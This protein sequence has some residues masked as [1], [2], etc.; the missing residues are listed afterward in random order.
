MGSRR[1]PEVSSWRVLVLFVLAVLALYIALDLWDRFRPD[2][3]YAR[4]SPF[5]SS[6]EADFSRLYQADAKR[7]HFRDEAFRALQ[8]ECAEQR[9]PARD[10]LDYIARLRE[11]IDPRAK[12]A[13]ECRRLEF[14]QCV[15]LLREGRAWQEREALSRIWHLGNPDGIEPDY[16]FAWIHLQSERREEAANVAAEAVAAREK[17]DIPD[18]VPHLALYAWLLENAGRF[19]DAKVVEERLSRLAVDPAPPREPEREEQAANDA[20][21]R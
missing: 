16:E 6:L 14:G 9:K 19:D 10:L 13:I 20:R 1:R 7:R 21:P 2:K 12:Q 3:P 4:E 18:L 11:Y 8:R 5:G 15:R 17:A